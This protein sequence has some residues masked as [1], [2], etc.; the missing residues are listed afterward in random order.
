MT[1]SGE[2]RELAMQCRGVLGTRVEQFLQCQARS[3][4]QAIFNKDDAS[5]SAHSKL[6]DQPEPIHAYPS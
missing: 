2:R 1:Q 4:A 5:R 6:A 3:G